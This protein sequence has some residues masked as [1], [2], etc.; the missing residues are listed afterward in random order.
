MSIKTLKNRIAVVAVAGLTAGVISVIT[1]PAVNAAANVAAGT[2]QTASQAED[3]L[4]IATG[5]NT[6]GAAVTSGVYSSLRSVGLVNVSDLN[7]GLVTSTT[8]TAVLLNTGT[9][10]V[11]SATDTSDKSSAI[12]VT[13]GVISTVTAASSIAPSL[14]TARTIVAVEDDDSSTQE[15]FAVAI[16]P[17]AGATTMTVQMYSKAS[18]TAATLEA[19]PTA[20]TLVGSITVTI[21]TASTA[22]VLS[23]ANS[24]VFTYDSTTAPANSGSAPADTTTSG[25][26]TTSQAGRLNTLLVAVKDAF[27]TRL[28]SQAALLQ[29]TATNGAI[30][31]IT[32]ASGGTA[33][34][35]VGSTTFLATSANIDGALIGVTT[36]SRAPLS[37]VVTVTYNGTVIGTKSLTFTGSIA[38]INISSPAFIGSLNQTPTAAGGTKGAVVSFQDAAGNTVYPA[39]GGTNGTYYPLSGFGTDPSSDH[40]VVLSILPTSTPV[41]GYVDWVCGAVASKKSIVARYTNIDGTTVKSAPVTVSCAGN[42]VSYTASMNKAS[43]SPGEIAKLS[44][45]FF[46]S[47]GNPANDDFD[48]N[49]SMVAGSV[50][51]GGGTFVASAADTDT[52]TLGIKEYSIITTQ[53][54]GN[55]Q[56]V[57]TIP[58]L[59]T[60]YAGTTQTV[61]YTVAAPAGTVGLADVLKS[62]VTLIASINKQIQALQKLIL[63]R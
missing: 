44:V 41:T 34:A 35:G 16:T 9:L 8:Q 54:P 23:T 47:K 46:D 11:Y 62:M 18:T 2:T 36:P 53:T 55:Y 33:T 56:A 37:T 1:S 15:L 52:S 58:T 45:A 38:K 42:A 14:N 32:A 20:G 49:D 13:N 59:N 4:N 21:A 6:T 24:G 39:S 40:D 19:A 25:Y 26:G 28:T 5:V 61:A 60:S 3:T 7:G 29:V 22:G 30:V 63:R 57:V 43:Y 51:T 48:W 50:T 17:N 27:G 12:V 10:V 31:S